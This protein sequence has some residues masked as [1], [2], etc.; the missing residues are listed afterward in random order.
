[1]QLAM[2]EAGGIAVPA[3][4]HRFVALVNS[5]FAVHRQ[6]ATKLAS[7][8]HVWCERCNRTFS[9]RGKLLHDRAIHGEGQ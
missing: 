2:A 5:R 6:G 3:S 8:E 9:Q 7:S 1:M 4:V